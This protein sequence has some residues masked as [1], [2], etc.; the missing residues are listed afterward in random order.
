MLGEIALKYTIWTVTPDNYLHSRAFDDIAESLHDAFIELG[1]ECGLTFVRPPDDENVIILGANLLTEYVP[2]HWIIYNLEQLTDGSPWMTSWYM[3]LLKKYPVWDYCQSNLECLEK[4]KLL[5]VGYMPCLTRIPDLTA[6]L[7][8]NGQPLDILF[9]GSQNERRMK[10]YDQLK[11]VCNCHWAFGVYGDKRDDLIAHA[12]VVVNVH[13]YESK[14]FEIV[15][16]SYLLANSKCIVS[17]T[18]VGGDEFRNCI[19]FADYDNIPSVCLALVKDADRRAVLEKT[20]FSVFSKMSQADNL[21]G[22]L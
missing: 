8:F 12:K 1:H 20:G 22:V 9:Y 5:P 10:I 14:L 16:C 2:E 17:E 7:Y 18:G 6:E 21:R 15:R 13:F 19:A 11:H 3:N 4:G